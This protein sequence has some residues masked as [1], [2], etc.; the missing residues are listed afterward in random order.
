[1]KLLVTGGAGFIGSNFIHYWLER[2]PRDEITDVDKFTYAADRKNLEGLPE[3]RHK[4]V[5]GDI[6]D[7]RLMDEIVK[8]VDAVVNLAAETHVDNSINNSE[9]F[10]HSNIVGV[11]TLLEASRRYEKRFHQVS[12]YDEQTRALTSKGFKYYWELKQG[13]I[14]LSINPKTE[15]L[16]EKEIEKVIIQNYTGEL[17]HF[18]SSRV[19]LEVTPNHRMLYKNKSK[20]NGPVIIGEAELV[21][22]HSPV[23]LLRGDW[24]GLDVSSMAL[25][26]I[27]KVPTEDLFYL[28]GI[29]IGDGFISP[30]NKSTNSKSG[31]SKEK[32][33][34]MKDRKGR[35]FKTGKIGKRDFVESHSWRIF[36]EIPAIDKARKR[37]EEVLK[38]LGIPYTSQKGKAGEHLYFTSEHWVNFFKQ[39]GEGAKNKNIPA[40]LLRFDKKYLK[41]LFDGLIDSDGTYGKVN[42]CYYTTSKKLTKDICE[43][44]FKIGYYPVINNRLT[45]SMYQGR[46]IRGSSF[47][48]GFSNKD[49][50]GI[51]KHV[52]KKEK[53][54]GKVWCVKVK[55]NKNL[56]VERNGKLALC[57]N[58]D[59]V[60]GAL[61]INSKTKFTEKTAYSPRNPYSATKA[62][63]DHLVDAY[64]NTYK[65]KTT[66]S[67]CSNNF[68]PRQHREKLLPKT[69]ANALSGR[70]I[71]IYGNGMQV[72]DWI[73]VED[74]CT[75]IELLL[76]K[77]EAGEKYLVSAENERH[78]LDVVR[79]ILDMLDKPRSLI[80]HVEDRAGHDV[81]YA[82]NP[83][84]IRSLG[85][86]PKYNKN[87]FDKAL[88]LTV[89]DYLRRWG[90]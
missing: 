22:K 9:P 82:L 1:M 63:A 20:P 65:L 66:I 67:N 80:E 33:D 4:L 49:S 76:K 40:W 21:S 39:F 15:L 36:L 35:F 28:V 43:L 34:K 16:E 53:Y 38:H 3:G 86:K 74:H 14:V 19:D 54:S 64:F 27:G 23:K 59:E 48:I 7:A 89:N 71:P 57:G 10:I 18:Q 62:A 42:M 17:I 85:W 87:N 32:R 60:Y 70:K 6:A 2:H 13:D 84:K 45:A 88:E 81:R 50:I 11:Y 77:G 68:G 58:T 47:R 75:A 46:S 72:R 55:D 73:Y 44:A 78:N 37:T 30:Q 56:L 83:G 5:V 25:S 61:K 31:L 79:S 24:K 69:I 8:D 26:E 51:G 29:F 52:A 41:C 90:E 12:C